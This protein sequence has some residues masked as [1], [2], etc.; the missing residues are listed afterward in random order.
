MQPQ[1][2]AF[3]GALLVVMNA[4][5]GRADLIPWSYQWNADPIVINANPLG[6]NSPATGGI[7][8]I[9]GASP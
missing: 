2:V 9:P 4:S 6:P 1:R 5:A 8:L 3:A 7:T